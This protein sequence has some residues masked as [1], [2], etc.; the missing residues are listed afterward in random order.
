MTYR[1][2]H[3]LALGVILLAS[4]C[5]GSGGGAPPPIVVDGAG[6]ERIDSA[7]NGVMNRHAPPGIAVAVVR[8]GKLAVAKSYG[9]ADLDGMEPLRPDHLFRIASISKPVTGMAAIRAI[10]EGL[11]DPDAAVFDILQSYLPQSGADPRLPLMTVKHLMHHT[12]GWNIVDYPNDPL[13]RSREIAEAVGSTMPPDPNALTRWVAMQPLDFDPGSS[14]AYTNIGYV[15]L[16]RVLEQST[17]FAYED[18]VR[19][20]VLE[21]AGVTRA[22]LGGITRA[23]RRPDEVEYESF[24]NSIWTSVFDGD[25]VVPE[26]AYGGINLVGLDASS[27]WLFSV[28]DLVRLAAA[29]DGDAGYPE[30]ISTQSFEFMTAIGTPAGTTPLGVA[31]FLGTNGT[32]DV[33]KW[34]HGGGMPGTT[35][36]LARLPDGVII[37]AISNTALEQDFFGDLAVGLTDAVEGI[38]DW[39]DTDLFP[40]FP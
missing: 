26:P 22:Q 40:Q 32:G 28:V 20:F 23:K 39:P 36:Y 8:N 21:P 27:A 10:E 25:S 15:V 24:Q 9:S 2:N 11:L 17:G 12:G 29:V 18:F 16:G 30:I 3:F 7:M 37:A 31:W 13:F 5:G 19:R 38:V 4:A 1:M 34:D 6:I 35:A 14:F 33:V